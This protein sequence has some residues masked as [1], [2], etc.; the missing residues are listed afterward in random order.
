MTAPT[1][2]AVLVNNIKNSPGEYCVSKV[3]TRSVGPHGGSLEV[4]VLIE[5]RPTP[6]RIPVELFCVHFGIVLFPPNTF[7]SFKYPYEIMAVIEAKSAII[8]GAVS[9]FF[10]DR[11]STKHEFISASVPQIHECSDCCR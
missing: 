2:W 5:Y 3:C 4:C 9:V 6:Q 11:N 8:L 1:S 10:E 7:P